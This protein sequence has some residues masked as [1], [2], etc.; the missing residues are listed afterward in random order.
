VWSYQADS[1]YPCVGFDNRGAAREMA[2]QVLANGHRQ[3]AMICGLTS[4]NDRAAERVAGV[5][6]ALAARGISLEPP[7]LAETPY[8]TGAR[9]RS[10]A[11]TMSRRR[12]RCAGPAR[13]ASTCRE[14]CQ[15]SAST[16]LIWRS[17]S[18]QP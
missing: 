11:A 5:R 14:I 16:T 10:F 7:Y 2:E 17:W 3:I 13:P 9:R 8:T 6:D 1:P 18:S 12:A 4:G 15:L